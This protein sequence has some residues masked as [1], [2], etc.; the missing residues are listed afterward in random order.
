M[1]SPIHLSDSE[2]AAVMNAARP[3]PPQDRDRFLQDIANELA[4][5]PMLGDGAVYRAITTVQRRH[6][7]PPS[8]G[9]EPRLRVDR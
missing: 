7:D 4:G 6:F 5:L 9:A 3:L 2:L 1:P 8:L